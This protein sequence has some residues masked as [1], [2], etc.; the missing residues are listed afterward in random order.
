MPTIL[1][2]VLAQ[3]HAIRVVALVALGAS[4]PGWT[5]EM[6]RGRVL[7]TEGRPIAGAIVAMA[8]DAMG[9][10]PMPD[11]YAH[12]SCWPLPHSCLRPGGECMGARVPPWDEGLRYGCEFPAP[13]RG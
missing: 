4:S 6:L 3:A 9:H 10:P 1:N 13:T 11:V 12:R 7:D 8:Q 2:L 5:Q